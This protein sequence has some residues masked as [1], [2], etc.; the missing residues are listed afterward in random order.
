MK[1]PKAFVHAIPV[2]AIDKGKDAAADNLL[3]A[4]RAE[5]SDE[6]L[7]HID[8]LIVDMDAD[9]IGRELDHAPEILPALHRGRFG[10]A[11]AGDIDHD[12]EKLDR[13]AVDGVDLDIVTQPEAAA[14]GGDHA[15]DELVVADAEGLVVAEL[16][17]VPVIGVDLV[18]PEVRF[19]Q[20]ALHRITEK[21]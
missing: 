8:I 7:V 18:E 21:P 1:A 20:P 5:D 17:H 10:L 9:A 2:G 13:Y 19:L 3:L 15:I 14:V 4:F 11:L 16:R 12:A 6:G